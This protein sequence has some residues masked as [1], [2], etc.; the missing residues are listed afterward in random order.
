MMDS[1]RPNSESQVYLFSIAV[2]TTRKE[3]L[4]LFARW[5]SVLYMEVAWTP[6]DGIGLM[7][8][9]SPAQ[10]KRVADECDGLMLNGLAIRLQ[11]AERGA[12]LYSQPSNATQILTYEKITDAPPPDEDT[13]ACLKVMEK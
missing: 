2:G 11:L 6:D 7:R 5:G 9:A 4:N 13:I 3:L 10:A 8:M 1:E 12:P